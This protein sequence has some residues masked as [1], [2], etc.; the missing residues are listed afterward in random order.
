MT[1]PSGQ[2]QLRP[3]P[4]NNY[5]Q[6]ADAVDRGETSD[7]LFIMGGLSARSRSRILI[8]RSTTCYDYRS[9]LLC[10]IIPF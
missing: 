3:P 7:S 8:C 1:T 10:I 4:M 6:Y 5:Y 9:C 2:K